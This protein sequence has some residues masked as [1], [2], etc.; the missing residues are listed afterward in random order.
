MRAGLLIGFDCL[1]HMEESS[2]GARLDAGLILTAQAVEHCEIARYGTLKAWAK[3]LGL[4]KAVLL[5]E[6][7]LQEEGLPQGA[8][9]ERVV[10]RQYQEVKAAA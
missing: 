5:L 9:Q 3:Q 4:E 7:T 8:H 2:K 6:P 10:C 1:R